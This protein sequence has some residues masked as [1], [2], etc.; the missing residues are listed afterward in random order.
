MCLLSMLWLLFIVVKLLNAYKMMCL[1][2]SSCLHIL[3]SFCFVA[4]SPLWQMNTLNG[5]HGGHLEE[6]PEVE[7]LSIQKGKITLLNGLSG[8]ISNCT[9]LLHTQQKACMECWCVSSEIFVWENRVG[10]HEPIIQNQQEWG[11]SLSN[12]GCLNKGELMLLFFVR[13]ECSK[14]VKFL[15]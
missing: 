2:L 15:D 13:P 4:R 12:L 11:K 6:V 9:A 5:W 7:K 3:K 10:D 1:I 8:C 14:A